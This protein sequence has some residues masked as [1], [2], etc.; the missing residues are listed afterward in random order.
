MINNKNVKVVDYVKENF[1]DYYLIE[2]TPSPDLIATITT[3]YLVD[4]LKL[5]KVAYVEGASI[6]PIVRINNGVAEHPIRIYASKEHK[7]LVL[8]SDQVI[9]LNQAYNFTQAINEWCQTKKIKGII[10]LLGMVPNNTTQDIYGAADKKVCLD[11]LKN[12]NV[13]ILENGL[14]SGV[15]AQ[16]LINSKNIDNFVLLA[17]PGNNTNFNSA[18]KLLEL[19][20]RMFKFNISTQPLEQESKKIIAA[21]KEKMQEMYQQQATSEKDEKQKMMFV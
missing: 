6:V 18:A 14:I 4:T 8:L 17:N 21:I 5:Q 1:K 15:S 20:G 12:N 16:I 19:L 9:D 3:R 10:S 13:K 2:G 7:F 11:F